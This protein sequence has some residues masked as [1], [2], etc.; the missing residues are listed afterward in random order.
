MYAG[1]WLIKVSLSA[2]SKSSKSK[3]GD[4]VQPAKLKAGLERGTVCV[5]VCAW[6]IGADDLYYKE[7]T[8]AD[9]HW[10]FLVDYVEGEYWIVDDQYKPYQK[11]IA[12]NTDFQTAEVYFL[13][14]NETGIAP[15]DRTYF[16]R[17]LNQMIESLKRLQIILQGR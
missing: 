1:N 15:N 13:K 14:R 3:P 9:G 7:A 2:N 8:D 6:K 11:R 4:T 12:W 10:T 16:M 17:L 5:S